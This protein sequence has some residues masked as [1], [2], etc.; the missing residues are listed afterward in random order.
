MGYSRFYWVV[1][2]QPKRNTKWLDV[3]DGNDAYTLR[4]G[5]G[6]RLQGLQ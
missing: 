2:S 3:R 4:A 1:S 5:G 6:S